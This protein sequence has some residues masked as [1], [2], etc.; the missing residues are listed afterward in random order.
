MAPCRAPRLP[1][2]CH[3]VCTAIAAL[4]EQLVFDVLQGMGVLGLVAFGTLGSQAQAAALVADVA[5]GGV[6]L[7]R[8]VVLEL[9]GAHELVATTQGHVAVELRVF[10]GTRERI[11]FDIGGFV[12]IVDL[13]AVRQRLRFG[14]RL[15]HVLDRAQAPI[16]WHV[17][18]SLGLQGKG[19]AQRQRQQAQGWVHRFSR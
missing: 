7:F 10:F 11:T 5:L 12:G 14:K 18:G 15:D 3:A 16:R 1:R 9:L 2:S 13:D 19:D 17:V 6:L 4:R 8:L